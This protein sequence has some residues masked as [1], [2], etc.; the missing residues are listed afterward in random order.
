MPIDGPQLTHAARASTHLMS[1]CSMSNRSA[2]LNRPEPPLV[3]PPNAK[4]FG[5]LVDEGVMKCR[6]VGI[7]GFI[8]PNLDVVSLQPLIAVA[9]CA[10]RTPGVRRRVVFARQRR[11]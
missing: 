8:N 7:A 9:G 4:V 11:R 1:R 3:N 5:D 2:H 10:L 6:L